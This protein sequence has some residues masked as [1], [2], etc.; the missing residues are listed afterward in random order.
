MPEKLC[1]YYF[2]SNEIK[3][4]GSNMLFN[5]ENEVTVCTDNFHVRAR[6]DK[7]KKLQKGFT[8]HETGHRL[9]KELCLCLEKK[10]QVRVKLI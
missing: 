1:R 9:L 5:L 6:N 8:G 7:R 4:F 10:Y 2:L 3:C